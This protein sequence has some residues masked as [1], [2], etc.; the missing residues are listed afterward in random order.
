[1][2][3]NDDN[4]WLTRLVVTHSGQIERIIQVIH[5]TAWDHCC[6]LRNG[7]RAL[8]C[9]MNV[10][11]V[12][13]LP[14]IDCDTEYIRTCVNLCNSLSSRVDDRLSTQLQRHYTAAYR[15]AATMLWHIDTTFDNKQIWTWC[16]WRFGIYCRI[17][18]NLCRDASRDRFNNIAWKYIHMLH[19]HQ[20]HIFK[21]FL[22][23]IFVCYTSALT[24]ETKCYSSTKNINGRGPGPASTHCTWIHQHD[25]P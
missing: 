16:E 24:C 13:W 8:E 7:Q 3:F 21:Y 17:C 14:D 9:N 23:C 11:K 20:A 15:N 19:E 4:G 18:W 25:G 5:A 10:L 22:I 6:G 1:M 2:G 12:Q